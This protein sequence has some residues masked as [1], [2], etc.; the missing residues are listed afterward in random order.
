MKADD[1]TKVVNQLKARLDNKAYVANAPKSVVD[2]TRE[3]LES[4][5]LALKKVTDEY[6]RFSSAVS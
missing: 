6:Q 2:E 1:Q 3:Q 5:E 4:A